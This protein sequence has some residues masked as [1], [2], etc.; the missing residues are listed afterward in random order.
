[1]GYMAVC[2]VCNISVQSVIQSDRSL[3]NGQRWLASCRLSTNLL[4]MLEALSGHH[5][6]H[7]HSK[8]SENKPRRCK[9]T[10]AVV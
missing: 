9:A 3:F 1:M 7:C 2:G 8:S 10:F 5:G 6:S 4:L